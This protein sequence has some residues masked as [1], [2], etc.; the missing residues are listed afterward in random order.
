V[1]RGH[2]YADVFDASIPPYGQETGDELT[3]LPYAYTIK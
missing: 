1:V 3:A 2:L